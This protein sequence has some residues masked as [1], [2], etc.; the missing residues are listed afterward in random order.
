M[1]SD[2]AQSDSLLEPLLTTSEVAR[3]LRCSDKTIWRLIAS[4]K[5]KA[6]KTGRCYRFRRHDVSEFIKRGLAKPIKHQ[7]SDNTGFSSN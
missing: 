2:F 6:V 1:Q 5:L 3:I 4:G 7:T